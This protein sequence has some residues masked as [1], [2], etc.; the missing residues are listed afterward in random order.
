MQ[1]LLAVDKIIKYF[2]YLVFSI[3]FSN[4]VAFGADFTSCSQVTG[5]SLSQC[6]ALVSLYDSIGGSSWKTTNTPCNWS[7][8]SCNS[9]GDVTSLS[10]SNKG[11][12]GS[13]PSISGL[14]QVYSLY[15]SGNNITS[16]SNLSSSGVSTLYIGGNSLSSSTLTSLNSIPSL[17]SLSIESS[18]LTLIPSEILNLTNLSSLDI[19]NNS[20][21]QFPTEVTSLSN[22]SSLYLDNNNLSSIPTGF[23]FPSLQTINLDNNQFTEIS[24][25][26]TNFPNLRYLYLKSNQINSIPTGFTLSSLQNLYL[27]DNQFTEIPAEIKNFPNLTYLSLRSNQVSSISSQI[28]NLG[29]LETLYLDDNQLTGTIPAEIINLSS[30]VYLYLYDNQISSIPTNIGNLSSLQRLYLYDNQITSLPSQIGNLTNLTY[31]YLYNNQLTGSIP[32]SLEN[33]TQLIYLKLN[34]N[35]LTGSIPT[36]I[37]NLT[38]LRYLY[39]NDNQ[40]TDSIPTSIESLASLQYLYLNNNQLSGSIPSG[41]GNLTSLIYLFLSANQLTG[42]IPTGITNLSGLKTPSTVYPI[43]H[44]GLGIACSGLTASPS[45]ISFLD[46]KMD[47]TWTEILNSA[48]CTVIIDN[49]TA[50]EVDG[51]YVIDDTIDINV[52]FNTDVTVT[53]TPQLTIETG[54]TDTVLNYSSGSGTDTLIFTYTVAAG[55]DSSDLDYISTTA[56]SLNGGSIKNDFSINADL[57]LPTSGTTGSLA[58]NKDLVIDGSP[59]IITNITS[60][61]NNGTY[62]IGDTIDI[63]IQ[64]AREVNVTGTPQ[65]TL[66]TGDIDAVV[67]YS[68][69]SGTDTLIFSYTIASGDGSTDLDYANTT[70]LSFN[71]GTIPNTDLT[72]PTSGTTGSLAANK[73]LV[74][75]IPIVTNITATTSNGI[76]SIGDTINITIQFTSVVNVTG[77]PQLILETGTTNAVA[78]YSSGSGTNTVTFA[79]TVVSWHSSDDL[80]YTNTTALTLNSGTIKD[81]TD[82]NNADLALPTPATTGSLAANKALIIDGIPPTVLDI[83]ATNINGIYNIGKI[84]DITI[85]FDDI[86]N[87]TGTPQLTLETG[88]ADKIIN[89]SSGSGTNTLTFT[90][91]VTLG[92]NTTDLDYINDTALTLN[93]G[94]IQDVNTNNAVLALPVPSTTNSLGANKDLEIDGIPPAVINVTATTPN[95]TFNITDTIDITV[96]FDDMVYV[97][98]TPQL[99]LNT[100]PDIIAV[101]YS[102]GSGTN[103][104][105]FVYTAVSG[106]NSLD[107][108]YLN[109]TA[110]S[111]NDGTIQDINT[112]NGDL[113]LPNPGTIGSLST[114]KNLVIDTRVPDDPSDLT[115]QTGLTQTNLAWTDNSINETGF[116][117]VQGDELI[118]ITDDNIGKY[119]DEDLLCRHRYNYYVTA[120]NR[121]GDSNTISTIAETIECVTYQLTVDKIGDGNIT[122]VYGII[123][124]SDCENIFDDRDEVILIATSDIGWIF[125]SWTG[126]CD[127]N[128]EV[129]INGDKTC[130][131][132]FLKQHALTISIEGGEGTI[133]DCGTS[134]I[135]TYLN[136]EIINLTTTSELATVWTGDC[137]ENGTVV[138][139]SN[140]TCIATFIDGYPVTINLVGKGTIKTVTKECKEDCQEIIAA[141]TTTSLIA[142]P[143]IE[144]VLDSWSGDCDANG[145]VDMTSEKECTANFIKDPNIPNNG[146]G[147]G[148]GIHDADQP[149]VVSMPDK[150]SGSYL[151]LDISGN[152]T[153]KEIY[154]DLAENQDY[155]EEKYIFPQGLVYFEL[156]GTEADITIY[157]HSL[158]KL[159]TT[160]IFQKFGTKIPGDMNTLD[161]YVMPNVEFDTVEIGNKSVVTVSYH[162]TDGGFGDNTGI[163]GWIVDPGGIAF[164]R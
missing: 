60:T 134:C 132:I 57:T 143:E 90:Y 105:T 140:K 99:T 115:Y 114:N 44:G 40:L 15:L 91:T 81:S 24:A 77:T 23:T 146:D 63:T 7:G 62:L 13:F 133:N 43:N 79:Y 164:D 66:E 103:T 111:A 122:N 41:I 74:V 50:T 138:M 52:Q 129:K 155:F 154:T 110:L 106:E 104:L 38:S 76:H 101:D 8:V 147:N 42:S 117:I 14:N 162:L 151:T 75:G 32:T 1:Q 54:T 72:L 88:S 31:L 121:N 135:Q 68:S 36:N 149:N 153:I 16:F 34:N 9:S 148:D 55:D 73:N 97:T 136:G 30:L 11:I 156:E 53:G 125:D 26:I 144:W 82:T 58:D 112:N 107:L 20:F 28:A 49:I 152:V 163:D 145:I 131:A 126:D 4:T 85:Q 118:S 29:S 67:D 22:L 12:S 141:N 70:A 160:P 2:K 102:N 127:E 3:V 78:N 89:Y 21:T 69:G 130:T 33:L 80:D 96:Q 64:F 94:T 65:L 123:C 142:E 83:T 47:P 116:K 17:R 139:D 61:A 161:W 35:Q 113:T 108:D 100:E 120:T 150:S 87:V 137:D 98:N 46:S 86:I 59:I 51:T 124:G 119:S 71:G 56:L 18:G 92:N 159:R 95:N 128:G 84:V 5:I 25:K 48:Q 27:D 93:S 10:L 109:T 158:Q 19:G 39:L 37:G 45:I 157:Y 6:N